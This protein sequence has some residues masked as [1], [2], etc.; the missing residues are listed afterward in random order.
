[1]KVKVLR[2]FPQTRALEAQ[3]E[4]ANLDREN[5][6]RRLKEQGNARV[7]ELQNAMKQATAET[8]ASNVIAAARARAEALTIEAQAQATAL[9]MTAEAEAEAVRTKARADADISNIF[10]QE[11][12]KARIE[13]ERTRA[14]GDRTTFA[15]M[16]A[17]SSGGGGIVG[18]ASFGMLASQAAA[19][20]A[21][22]QAR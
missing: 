4:S 7:L 10:A 1:V 17:M 5:A 18:S 15:P 14:F 3:V 21:G 9:K 22:Q 19:N 2:H 6:N 13:V 20:R 8:E 12:A 16:E 11:L